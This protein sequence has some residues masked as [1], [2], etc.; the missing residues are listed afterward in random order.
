MKNIKLIGFVSEYHP[1]APEAQPYKSY[2]RESDVEDKYRNEVLGYIKNGIL[3]SASMRA[4]ED[5]V[6]GEDVGSDAY[7]TDGK[8]IWPEYMIYYLE[9][10]PNYIIEDQFVQDLINKGFKY[11]KS[12]INEKKLNFFLSK[13]LY[14]W[15]FAFKTFYLP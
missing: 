6:S 12:K 5:L 10:K 4:I 14:G 9:N 11:D 7:Y 15:W 2:F 3:F 1:D 8:W 13:H